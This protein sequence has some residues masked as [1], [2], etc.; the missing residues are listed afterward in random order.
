MK[1]TVVAGTGV[2]AT[3]IEG[4][5]LA[6]DHGLISKPQPKDDDKDKHKKN[7]N[8][9]NDNKDLKSAAKPKENNKKPGDNKDSKSGKASESYDVCVRPQ[10]N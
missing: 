9:P 5:K 7:I 4:G 1:D 3:I 8:K 2:V 6:Y 10:L